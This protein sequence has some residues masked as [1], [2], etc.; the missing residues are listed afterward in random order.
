M[1]PRRALDAY[2]SSVTRPLQTI[3][4]AIANK[5]TPLEALDEY[6]KIVHDRFFSDR[7]EGLYDAKFVVSLAKRVQSFFKA[8]AKDMEKTFI[9]KI[10]VIIYGGLPNG[11]SSLTTG[12][13]DLAYPR[14]EFEPWV[15][16]V[17]KVVKEHLLEHGLPETPISIGQFGKSERQRVSVSP[18]E[19]HITPEAVTLRVTKPFALTRHD[20]I[21]FTGAMPPAKFASFPL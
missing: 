21:F 1:A 18:I 5:R 17:G 13:I 2:I 19:I 12:D 15:S 6:Y 16:G 11:R 7:Q 14:S 10:E 3:E 20:T 9:G 8:N 4:N